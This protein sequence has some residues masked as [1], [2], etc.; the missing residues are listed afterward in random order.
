MTMMPFACASAVATEVDGTVAPPNMFRLVVRCPPAARLSGKVAAPFADC[1]TPA[2]VATATA[3]AVSTAARS[4]REL[5]DMVDPDRLLLAAP[6]TTA[7]PLIDR[8]MFER[9][10]QTG[11][12]RSRNV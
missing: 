9:L 5:R 4:P 7:C 10:T 1:V 8:G 11:E 2:T 6:K 3:A 12:A